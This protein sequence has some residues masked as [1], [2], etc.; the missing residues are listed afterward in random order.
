[1][2]TLTWNALSIW[3]TKG[4]LQSSSLSL[5]YV[6]MHK[7][8]IA[9]LVP[10]SNNTNISEAVGR[11]MYVMGSE[12]ELDFGRVIVDQIVDHSRTRAKLKTIGLTSLI[13]SI[14][15]PQHLEVLKVEDGTSEDAKPLT[16]ID[17]LM[18][19][20]HVQDVE[21]KDDEPSD[22]VPEEEAT[23]LLIKA[24]EQEQQRFEAEIQFKK[25]RVVELQ[26]KIQALKTIGPRLTMILYQLILQNQRRSLQQSMILHLMVLIILTR[27]LS[28]MCNHLWA[29]F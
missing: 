17:K 14:L 10:T 25:S 2:K 21:I 19:G 26:A 11:M 4:Q 27:L 3:P 29:R 16:I 15:I 13:C 23:A 5:R 24:Y 18:I 9:N 22:V 6:V 20:K 8:A 28:L 12:Q 1:M 7:V